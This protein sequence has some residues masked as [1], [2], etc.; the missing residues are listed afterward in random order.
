MAWSV[1]F[2]RFLPSKP[3]A[4]GGIRWHSVASR[5]LSRGTLGLQKTLWLLLRIPDERQP[6]N[7]RCGMSVECPF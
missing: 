3:V 5:Y 2:G 7:H 1:C 6:S 4:F